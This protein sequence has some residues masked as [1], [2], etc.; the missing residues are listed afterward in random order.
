MSLEWFKSL[1][2]HKNPE[3][4]ACHM[5]PFQITPPGWS[6]CG[7]KAVL[8]GGLGL[9]SSDRCHNPPQTGWLRPQTLLLTVPEAGQP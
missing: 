5:P 8:P 2:L 3:A 7:K 1:F 4:R 6:C 9:V